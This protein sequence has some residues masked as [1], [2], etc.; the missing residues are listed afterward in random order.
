[1]TKRAGKKTAKTKRKISPVGCLVLVAIGLVIYMVGNGSKP[2]ERSQIV[3]TP[4]AV[5]RPTLFPPLVSKTKH[6]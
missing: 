2:A 6:Q 5:A 4:K 1:M 3:N